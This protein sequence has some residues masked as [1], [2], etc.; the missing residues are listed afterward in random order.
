MAAI[1]SAGVGSGLDIEGLVFK[2]VSA[3]G[4]PA[5]ARLNSQEA[6]LQADLS[7]FGSLKGALSSFQTSVQALK[8]ASA[9]K[10]RTATSSHPDLFSVSAN[11][12]AIAGSFSIIVDQLAQSAKMRS[13]DFTSDTEVVGEGS[14]AIG[15]G[16]A[17]FNIS[18]AADTT[19]AGIRDAINQ[20]EDNPGIKATIINVDSG[21]QLVLTSEKVGAANTITIAA[22][23][24]NASD[25]KDLTRLATASLTTIQSAQDAIIHIDGQQVTRNSNSFSDAISGVTVSLLKADPA[26]T[27]TLKISMDKSSVTAKVNEFI[28]S[29]NALAKTIS[30]LSGYNAATKTGGPLLGDATT[31]SVQNQIRHLLSTSVQGMG[32]IS[33]LADIGITSDKTGNLQ[34]DSAKLEKAMST[35]FDAI[36]NLFSSENGLAH[37]FDSLLKNYLSSDGPLSSRIEGV[38]KSIADITDQRKALNVKL[39]ALES[40]YRKQFTAMDALVGQLQSTG[41][42]LTQQLK[43]LPGITSSND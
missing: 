13:G 28:K 5:A 32:G 2:L 17:N 25:G 15:L 12:S 36:A 22:T 16:A 29:Y 31:R 3:E 30:G 6:A 38:G 1:T 7:A 43:S 26:I 24:A 27:G 4:Q 19:L 35:N 40:R 20:A 10:G 18:V 37:K 42:F 21:S 11:G 9:F 14:L 33:A 23:D 39:A 34:L 41:N 8:D